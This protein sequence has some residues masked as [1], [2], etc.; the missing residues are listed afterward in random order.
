MIYP[1]FTSNRHKTFL[2][3][4]AFKLDYFDG[5]IWKGPKVMVG[6]IDVLIDKKSIIKKI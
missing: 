3:L 4:S 2:F 5:D 6:K 1:V